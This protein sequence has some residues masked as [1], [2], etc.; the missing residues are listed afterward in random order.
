MLTA[1]QFPATHLLK[2]FSILIFNEGSFIKNISKMS[3]QPQ[4]ILLYTSLITYFIFSIF[5]YM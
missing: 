3:F 5:I 4:M 2:L 1:Y